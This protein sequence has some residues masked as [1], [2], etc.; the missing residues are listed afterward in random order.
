MKHAILACR[1]VE[2]TETEKQVALQVGM[3]LTTPYP[4]SIKDVCVR[5]EREVWVGP[6]QQDAMRAAAGAAQTVVS[7]FTCSVLIADELREEPS[8]RV[9]VVDLGNVHPSDV[10][11]GPDR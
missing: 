2:P 10:P 9:G 3:D 6:R 7:C 8:E 1:S 4:G 11:S 5:C